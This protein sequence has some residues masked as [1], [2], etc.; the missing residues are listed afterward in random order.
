M[1]A[2]AVNEVETIRIIIISRC[3]IQASLRAPG[4][5]QRNSDSLTQG[6]NLCLLLIQSVRKTMCLHTL[7]VAL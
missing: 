1:T 3:Q 2:E 5:A 6:T 4:E 7:L